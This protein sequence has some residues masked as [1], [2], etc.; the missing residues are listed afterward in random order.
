M[1]ATTPDALL[2][3]TVLGAAGLSLPTH[4]RPTATLSTLLGVTDDSSDAQRRVENRLAGARLGVMS[5]LFRALRVKHPP[6]AK[7]C[8]RVSL[9]CSAFAHALQVDDRQ[10]SLVEIAA[11]LH[12]IGKIGV[13]D[14]L[15]HKPSRLDP[16]EMVLMERHR[17]HGIQ[18]LEACCYEREILE[19]VTHAPTWFNGTRPVPSA[20]C[21]EA[22]PW[23]A[24]VV[25]ILDAYDAMTTDLV[26]RTA[27]SRQRAI[28][29]L[30][31]SAPSQFDPQLVR[32]FARVFSSDGLPDYA[33]MTRRW[34]DQL[35]MAVDDFW[36]LREPLISPARS[37]ESVFQRRLLEAMHDGVVFIDASGHVLVWNQSAE[38]LTGLSAESVC[39]KSWQPQIV[40]MRDTDGNPIKQRNCPVAQCI[41]TVSQYMHRMTIT[42]L[43][44]NKVAVKVHVVPVLDD[45]GKCHGATML[46]HDATGETS[47]EKRVQN[48]HEIATTDALT[49][50]ANR[51]EFDRRHEKLV[52]EHSQSGIPCS[53]AI[54]DIDHF[55]TVNDVYGHQAGDAAL[56]EFAGLIQ[57][58]CRGDDLVARYGG[59]EFVV[60]YPGCH[61]DTAAEKVEE[62]RRELAQTPQGVLNGR[63]LT[64]SFGVTELQDGD[65]A[66]T[67]LRRAD[68]ALY[69]AKDSG[70]NRV[71]RLGSGMGPAASESKS[72]WLSWFRSSKLDCLIQRNLLADVPA[73]VVAEKVR[74]F[75][76]DHE[77]EIVETEENFVV[78]CVDERYMPL[79]RRQSDR[80]TS[81]VIELLLRE[82]AH[83]HLNRSGT[84]IEVTIRP[85]RIRDRRRDAARR[86]DQLLTSLKSYLMAQEV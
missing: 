40:D 58:H 43:A 51:A 46:I 14:H 2:P 65:S 52:R 37:V 17:A 27:L 84:L 16:D 1:E 41:R 48:L 62:I 76:A 20:V 67:M 12:D 49:G 13:P 7:H 56:I 33:E 80:P 9:G 31:A 85:K 32:E 44:R 86:A 78:L 19:I 59:E 70:R 83:A 45:D 81:L 6:T 24:R 75:I 23:G 25:A 77:A 8:L 30:L 18:I 82:N 64:A 54:C 15:L 36:S 28:D 63:S 60:L 42:N 66:E 50:V 22:L 72:R 71:E 47:L 55:K 10:R 57:R 39:H 5:S 61:G 4:I 53:M 35:A 74:G 3:Q 29:E 73:N 69:K 38:R 11:L 26:Y 79:Q 34:V 21:G 68:R